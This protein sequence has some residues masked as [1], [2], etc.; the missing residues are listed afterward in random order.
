MKP[1]STRKNKIGE[2][3]SQP[4]S[5]DQTPAARSDDS[6][7]SLL[8]VVGGHN[9]EVQEA[10]GVI[11]S[12][13]TVMEELLARMN[14][15]ITNRVDQVKQST[16]ESLRRTTMELIGKL[17]EAKKRHREKSASLEEEIRNLT[18]GHHDSGT[19]SAAL[20]VQG[21]QQQPGPSSA[22]AHHSVRIQDATLNEDADEGEV[23]PATTHPTN[24]EVV[25]KPIHDLISML[26][27][28]VALL[29]RTLFEMEEQ[30]EMIERKIAVVR[31]QN[32]VMQQTKQMPSNSQRSEEHGPPEYHN[33]DN[34]SSGPPIQRGYGEPVT[35]TPSTA[36]RSTPTTSTAG[37]ST[38]TSESGH[39]IS[40]VVT[41]ESVPHFK[42]ETPASEP[43]QECRGGGPGIA[44][45]ETYSDHIEPEDRP[46]Y[47]GRVDLLADVYEDA[48]WPC[49]EGNQD[50]DMLEMWDDYGLGA[51]NDVS[52][53]LDFDIEEALLPPSVA[54]AT[55]EAVEGQVEDVLDEMLS[56]YGLEAANNGNYGMDFDVE[57][58]LPT[59]SVAIATCEA[60]EGQAED[61]DKPDLS[62]PRKS[63]QQI[64]DDGSLYHELFGSDEEPVGL[65]PGARPNTCTSGS[66]PARLRQSRLL[67]STSDTTRRQW[68]QMPQVVVEPSSIPWLSPEVLVK[69]R[70]GR[71]RFCIDHRAW[72]P[73]ISKG[74]VPHSLHRGSR[75]RE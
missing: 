49:E 38:S 62:H 47:E 43:L 19:P 37:R 32:W 8:I 28:I 3:T 60:M 14:T 6:S 33:L 27:G 57:D 71:R 24:P 42:G 65:V 26:E 55:C 18:R 23:A 63:R 69:R 48:V 20:L 39:H 46:G 36:G 35:Q 53:G 41:R 51:L 74:F 1:R 56:N 68:D 25:Q 64:Q 75:C 50:A 7:A 21:R 70:G 59:Q 13:T 15:L 22:E 9:P 58:E 54:I 72:N 31:K 67:P 2:S 4:R 44:T 52:Y 40:Y 17:G 73:V 61:D 5:S 11:E 45:A 12:D 10:I 34:Q 30:I 16:E 29:V 66:A